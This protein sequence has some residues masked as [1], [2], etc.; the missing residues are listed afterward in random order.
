M[1]KKK[2]II[3]GAGNAG[4][5]AYETLVKHKEL[6][7]VTVISRESYL[8]YSP[9]STP[10]LLSDLAG[11]YPLHG[12][13]LSPFLTKEVA[14]SMDETEE[15]NNY[16]STEQ[17]RIILGKSVNK[18]IPQDKKVVLEDGRVL[19]Y[20]AVIIC[21]GA[22]PFNP[23]IKGK[24]GG[25]VFG[26][27]NQFDVENILETAKDC[28]HAVIIGAGT[29]G[30]EAAL[31]L[32]TQGVNVSVIEKANQVLPEYFDQKAREMIQYL[33]EE[34][35]LNIY[36]DST[37]TAINQDDTENVSS[38][39]L[40]DNKDIPCDLVIIAA[41]VQ[42]ET[43]VVKDS[44]IEVNRGILVNDR[45]ETNYKDVYA[46]GD[47]VEADGFLLGQKRVLATLPNVI[48]QAEI[49]AMNA[50]ELDVPKYESGL[51]VN[52]M[53]FNNNMFFSIGVALENDG[54]DVYTYISTE[55]RNYLKLVFNN[56]QLVSAMGVNLNLP[57]GIIRRL[58]VNRIHLRN[59]K[60]ILTR[61]PEVPDV[62]LSTAL[63]K[64]WR[65]N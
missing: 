60:N 50:L 34:N 15:T 59:Y 14:S 17:N 7:Q 6:C 22:K 19:S 32:A 8:R 54:C 16:F 62:W 55:K 44:G 64:L 52:V 56:D 27:D 36:L 10:Y 58:I 4:L 25:N 2:I 13:P 30:L 3:I 1:T 63:A 23:P 40:V 29:L 26:L 37:V 35:G 24:E 53:T 12:L 48:K 61:K 57:V 39:S 47:V 46:A 21:T 51:P 43:D 49:A 41:G 45:M 20:D 5:S 11:L 9:T 18:I 31:N 42:C 33:L 38:V 28:K 65:P